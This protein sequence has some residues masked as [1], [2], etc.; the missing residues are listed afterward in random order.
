MA[1]EYKKPI[2]LKIFLLA[3]ICITLGA[4]IWI[5]IDSQQEATL[6][7][8][9]RES[10]EPDTT[11]SLDKI[12]HTATRKGKREWSLEAASAHYI[13][14]TSQMVLDDLMITFFLDDASEIALTADKGMQALIIGWVFASLLQ[15]VGGFGV[16]VAVIAPIMVGLGFTP[17]S[18]VVVPSIGHSW[19]VTF[20]SLGSSFQV[21]PSPANPSA[22]KAAA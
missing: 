22:S 10:S 9:T 5:Y 8:P 16:P 14:K 7:E 20:G 12:H 2:K 11:L 13:G 19:A 3:T 18:A 1:T 17:L 4:V 21:M 15:G 6:T